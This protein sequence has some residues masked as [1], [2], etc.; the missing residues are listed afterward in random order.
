MHP[1]EIT[2]F[3]SIIRFFVLEGENNSYKFWI[4][5]QPFLVVQIN[6]TNI[7][8]FLQ[9][10]IFIVAI[11]RT[12][13]VPCHIVGTRW[14]ELLFSACTW[15]IITSIAMV[16]MCIQHHNMAVSLVVLASSLTVCQVS[17]PL[18]TY[19]RKHLSKHIQ[20]WPRRWWWLWWIG[21]LLLMI[22]ETKNH[23]KTIDINGGFPT[24]HLMAM[25][26]MK[27]Y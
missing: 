9:H 26:S 24:I 5:F 21:R 20:W 25:V 3:S 11:A 4:N 16:S 8:L 19:F 14:F 23:C 10:G 6:L 17:K 1:L 13:L 15:W 12:P 2:K 22:L 27:T 18:I 7:I